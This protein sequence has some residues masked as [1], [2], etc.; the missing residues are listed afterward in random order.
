MTQLHEYRAAQLRILHYDCDRS[1]VQAYW[2]S[3][4][5]AWIGMTRQGNRRISLNGGGLLCI[6]DGMERIERAL[7]R[8]AAL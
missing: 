8:E 4:R 1:M 7:S 6:R 3:G 2:A 5:D